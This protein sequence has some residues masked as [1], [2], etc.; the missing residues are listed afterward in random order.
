MDY[1]EPHDAIRH[2]RDPATISGVVGAGPLRARVGTSVKWLYVGAVG[3]GAA[4]LCRYR[5]DHVVEPRGPPRPR[6]IRLTAGE[7]VIHGPAAGHS[8]LMGRSAR[9][10]FSRALRL[11]GA[12]AAVFH[13][14]GNRADARH[15]SAPVPG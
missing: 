7:S 11:N 5:R 2:P 6:A 9:K 1:F 12:E 14:H 15:E 8:V 10:F 13:F 4:A 3:A